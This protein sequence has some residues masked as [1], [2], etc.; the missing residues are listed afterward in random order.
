MFSGRVNLM[1][2]SRVQDPALLL[3][4]RPFN[5]LKMNHIVII[6]ISK[7]LIKFIKILVIKYFE[8]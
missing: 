2:I 1:I 5:M 6:W 7:L 8:V 4:K 3:F